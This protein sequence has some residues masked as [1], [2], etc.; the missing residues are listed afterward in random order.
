[1]SVSAAAR[2]RQIYIAAG[3]NIV[4][5]LSLFLPWFALGSFDSISGWTAL[6]AP[7][8]ILLAAAVAIIG[9]FAEVNRIALPIRLDPLGVAAYA[10][11]IPLW[12]ATTNLISGGGTG[13]DW[14]LVVA[15][16]AAVVATVFAVRV[17][18]EARR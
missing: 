4:F 8:V 17:W 15:F 1:V 13:R 16:L 12:F 7:L 3:A 18:R 11:S 5:I 10:S 2:Q 9:L 14:G 6:P